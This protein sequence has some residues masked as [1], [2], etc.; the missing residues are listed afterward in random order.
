MKQNK[1][2]IPLKTRG[3]LTYYAA[4]DFMLAARTPFAQV[5]LC[6]LRFGT[7]GSIYVMF[8]YLDRKIGIVS[9]LDLTRE[10]KSEQGFT[11]DLGA[12]GIDVDQDVKFSHHTSGQVVFSK[13]GL[14]QPLPRRESFPLATGSG[15]VFHFFAYR[16]K[17]FEWFKKVKR[18]D[19]VVY[20]N[21]PKK[22]PLGLKIE[23]TWVPI[24][25]IVGRS[26]D[27]HGPFGIA[28]NAQTRTETPIVYIGQPDDCAMR[29]H[30][31]VVTAKEQEVPDGA[32]T[33]TMIFLGGFDDVTDRPPRTS[34]CLA[35]LYPS[36]RADAQST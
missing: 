17:G 11:Y 6:R 20:L 30:V 5:K 4:R 21:F 10:T 23:A 3:P 2:R 32:D 14:Q 33:P 18:E 31:L 16:L 27:R 29:E 7:D 19:V 22:H 8:P 25:H 13:T 36:A 1:R 12:T 15:A 28:V 26:L 35:F 24:D 34:G 9:E